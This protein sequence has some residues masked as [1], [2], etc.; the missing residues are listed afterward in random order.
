MS[1]KRAWT[2]IEMIMVMVLIG[3]L[4]NIAIIKVNDMIQLAKVKRVEADI[5]IL[6]KALYSYYADVG[7]YPS[8]AAS[9]VDPGLASNPGVTGWNGPYIQSWPS[10][11]P[12]GGA[13]DYQTGTY[14]SFDFDGTSGNEVWIKITS[15][16]STRASTI[17]KN[18]DNNN[19]SSGKI[20]YNAGSSYLD[21]YVS[22]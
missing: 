18:L 2:L 21:V 7:S 6:R 9:G 19:T 8:D 4:A 12:W 13:Y 22:G 20:I 5:Q 14:A 3:I 16:S 11:A 10:S 17:D 15:I 1:H